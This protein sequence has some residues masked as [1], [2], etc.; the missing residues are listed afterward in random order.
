MNDDEFIESATTIVNAIRS[1]NWKNGGV[2][3]I[4]QDE[5]I[6][7]VMQLARAAYSKGALD[8]TRE[9]AQTIDTAFQSQ[10]P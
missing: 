2:H 3:V 8:G 7:A 9:L 6:E 1:Q 5:A 4:D 10:Q